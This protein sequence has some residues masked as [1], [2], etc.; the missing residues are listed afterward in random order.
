MNG[1]SIAELSGDGWVFTNGVLNLSGI[2][3]YTLHGTNTIGGVQVFVAADST[4]ELAGVSIRSEVPFALE[5]GVAATVLLSGPGN[6]L[7]AS[8]YSHAGLFVPDGAALTITN[9]TADAKLVVIGGGSGAGIGG[10]NGD[11][12]WSG[13]ITIAGGIV[14]AHSSP[15][16]ELGYGAAIGAGE[17]GKCGPIRITGGRVYAYSGTKYGYASAGIGGSQGMARNGVHGGVEISGGTVYACGGYQDESLFAADIGDGLTYSTT[18]GINNGVVITGGNVVLA[19]FNSEKARFTQSRCAVTNM[20]HDAA[21]RVLHAVV[22]SIGTPD[23]AV[24]NLEVF[25]VTGGTGETGGTGVSYES[26][27]YGSRD[28]YADAN[29]DLYLWLPDGDYRITANGHGY[30]ATIDGADA[31]AVPDAPALPDSIVID[32]IDLASTSVTLGVTVEPAE[33]LDVHAAD[34]RVRASETLPVSTGNIMDPATVGIVPGISGTAT[35]TLP[36]ATGSAAP[37]SMF[38]KVEV[39]GP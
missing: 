14:E 9:A 29:G 20:A 21:S 34:L 35:L 4:V 15:G 22:V 8:R 30:T 18:Y 6:E 39:A 36:L 26:C 11:D 3:R 17:G 2:E 25:A 19:H 23:A 5:S 33:W 13:S 31:E 1:V 37:S 38:Y 28:L 7:V 24:T 12:Q 32:F 16:D 27:S 10:H